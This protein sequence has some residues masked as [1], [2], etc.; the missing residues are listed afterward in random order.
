MKM[1]VWRGGAILKRYS[2]GTVVVIAADLDAAWE[3]LKRE[4]PTTWA[5]L[6]AWT[7]YL[8]DP[9]EWGGDPMSADELLELAVEQKFDVS[10]E[11]SRPPPEVFEL[12]QAP[13][14]VQWGGE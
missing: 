2:S 10:F 12:D 4:E 13:V 1:F 8:T 9:S 6:Q 5:A 7:G 11:P 3:K 14:I